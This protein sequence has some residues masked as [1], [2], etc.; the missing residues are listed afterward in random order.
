MDIEVNVT[1]KNVK[2]PELVDIMQAAIRGSFKEE[3]KT[4]EGRK[5]VTELFD[6]AVDKLANRAFNKGREY[7]RT[8]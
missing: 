6:D 3:W 7:E 1:I 4:E 2:A 8:N 5:R